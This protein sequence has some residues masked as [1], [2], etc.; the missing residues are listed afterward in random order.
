MKR[1]IFDDIYSWS[2]F[3]EMRQIDFNG[4]LW[5]RSEGNVLIDP[6]AMIDSDLDQL[7]QLG[8]AALIV[9]TNRDHEREADAFRKRTGAKVVVHEADAAALEAPADRLVTDGEEIVPGLRAV[10]LRYGKSPGEIAL[11][12]PG[13]RA[14]LSGDLVVGEPVGALTLLADEKLADPPKA[15]LELR[16]ILALPFDAILVGDGHSILQDARQRLV[17][18]L[19]RRTDVYINRININ[20]IDWVRRDS[21]E[22]YN[23]DDKD[24]DPLI[25]AQR[26]GYR[27]I[28]LQ[29]GNASFPMHLHHFGE[30]MFYVMEGE[31]TLKTPRGD[32]TVIPGDF[33][34]FPTGEFGA[35][36]FVN[37]GDAACTLLAVGTVLPHDVSE[38]PDSNKV[39][40]FVA[41]R[42]FR[43]GD[44][45]S[46]WDGEVS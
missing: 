37:T 38:Y 12:F 11:Y 30:E 6:V 22:P 7:D 28:R 14:V 33:I 21:P 26:L 10:H 4:H 25:G 36:K 39:F 27:L 46:Y 2:I 32:L 1:S 17:E 43:K 45:V 35:H 5:V 13:K 42:I 19:Q 15:A 41:G 3:S 24:L 8:G 20:E 44:S 18:C 23:F 31:C 40:P 29:P 16:K 9:L 34:A